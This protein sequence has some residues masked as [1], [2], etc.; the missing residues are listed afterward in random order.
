MSKPSQ[1][2]LRLPI[3]KR[4]EIAIKV[5]VAKAIDEHTRLGLPIY[6][7]RNNRVV[8]LPSHQTLSSSKRPK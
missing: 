6:I 7:W 5:A 2:V 3:E 8:K 4:A 1:D